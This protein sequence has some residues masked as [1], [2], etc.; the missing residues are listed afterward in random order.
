MEEAGSG[1]KLC[2]K[3]QMR[4][5]KTGSVRSFFFQ[6]FEAEIFLHS[7]SPKQS[8]LHLVLVLLVWFSGTAAL[9]GLLY[10]SNGASG[11]IL[12]GSTGLMVLLVRCCH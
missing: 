10:W 9:T 4:R 8:G 11:P 2:V 7:K 6:Q 5:F 1:I 12:T 3:T